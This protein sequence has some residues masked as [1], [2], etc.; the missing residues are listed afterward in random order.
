MTSVWSA[1]SGDLT[2]WTT[3]KLLQ[4]MVHWATVRG[5]CLVILQWGTADVEI[6]NPSV[7]N[8]ELTNV[9]PLKPEL[10]QNIAMHALTAARSFFPCPNLYHPGPFTLIFSRSS[11][12]FFYNC[13][14]E[15]SDLMDLCF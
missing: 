2:D 8:P 7:E 14:S 13:Y 4:A 12:N 10:G 5:S 1:S 11:P 9:L 6:S 15:H 3:L